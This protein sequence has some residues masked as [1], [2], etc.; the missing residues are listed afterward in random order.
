MFTSESRAITLELRRAEAELSHAR[1]ELVKSIHGV[2]DEVTRLLA[3]RAWI[4][5]NPLLFLGSAFA[6]G[7]F[8]GRRD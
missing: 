3:W 8:L 2:E 1:D 6:L 4:R 7:F 5:R